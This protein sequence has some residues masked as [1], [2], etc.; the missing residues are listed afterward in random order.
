VKQV[1]TLGK[2]DKIY[3]TQR[4]GKLEADY[5][6]DAVNFIYDHRPCSER[7]RES[8]REGI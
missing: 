2:N 5:E 3:E 4:H 7:L 6:K 1:K 8:G